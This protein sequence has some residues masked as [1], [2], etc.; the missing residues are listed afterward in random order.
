MD[1]RCRGGCENWPAPPVASNDP[2]YET[3][4][5]P[6]NDLTGDPWGALSGCGSI[7]L[8]ANSA[9]IPDP[10]G[11]HN[12]TKI[13]FPGCGDYAVNRDFNVNLPDGTYRIS[14]SIYN[15]G[16]STVWLMTGDGSGQLAVGA[17]PPTGG[18]AFC[19][20]NITSAG[21]GGPTI[22]DL[23]YNTGYPGVTAQAA[24]TVY[25][26]NWKVESVSYP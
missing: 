11:G 4:R 9:D 25:A 13:E 2:I 22:S 15:A 5:G 7:V 19:S 16:V 17:C 6:Y 24:Q 20:F 18:W 3:V 12:S 1:R 8:T 26:F 23:G 14:A 10:N 21:A